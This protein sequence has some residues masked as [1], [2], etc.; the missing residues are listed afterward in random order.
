MRDHRSLL[1]EGDLM[2]AL[3]TAF[4]GFREGYISKGI[5]RAWKAGRASLPFRPWQRIH[6]QGVQGPAGPVL[7][8]AVVL[9]K[10]IP[11]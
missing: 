3:R 9:R 7:R 11:I 6:V 1:K 5:Q 10:G 8:A 4:R 2:D